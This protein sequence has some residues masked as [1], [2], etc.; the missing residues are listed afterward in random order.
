MFKKLR[1]GQDLI[2]NSHEATAAEI[3]FL[4]SGFAKIGSAKLNEAKDAIHDRTTV[5][6]IVDKGSM[7]HGAHIQLL[8]GKIFIP[9][10]RMGQADMAAFYA[11]GEF[12]HET[13][14]GN[15]SEQEAQRQ[16]D[17]VIKTLPAPYNTWRF[18]HGEE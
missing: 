11:F 9:I 10:S 14:G 13:M 15:L 4:D 1:I 5:L 6:Y 18:K 8:K 7:K 12:Q 17:D 3:S 16:I 2:A